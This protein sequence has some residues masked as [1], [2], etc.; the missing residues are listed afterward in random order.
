[1]LPSTWIRKLNLTRSRHFIFLLAILFFPAIH[2]EG[3]T[4]RSS[5]PVLYNL[6]TREGEPIDQAIREHY[7]GKYQ[8]VE[9]RNEATYVSPKLAKGGYPNPVFDNE[10][11]LVN[12]SVRVCFVVA[13]SGRL[14]DPFIFGPANP[15]LTGPV[16]EILKEYRAIPARVQGRPVAC[17]ESVKFRFGEAPRRRIH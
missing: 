7:S 16:L 8:L 15:L 3:G 14:V 11:R 5:N 12:G 13:A 9:L 17:V 2:A 1:M 10:N 4:E 6:I